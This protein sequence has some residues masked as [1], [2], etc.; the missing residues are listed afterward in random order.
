M[1]E[2]PTVSPRDLS[3]TLSSL[4]ELAGD[5]AYVRTVFRP[6]PVEPVRG[7]TIFYATT[8]PEA[9]KESLVH[10]LETMHGAHVAGITHNLADRE[11]LTR[12]LDAA[13]GSYE[14]LVTE[15]KAAAIDTAAA[16]AAHAGI[17]VVFADN[18]PV[19]VDGDLDAQLVSLA[20]DARARFETHTV[21]KP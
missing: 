5:V 14:I 16:R 9:V 18:V 10:H 1:A 20:G 8:A 15:L 21:A 4:N 17:H 11:A 12:D 6:Q 3:A 19:A 7:K 13:D 2:E